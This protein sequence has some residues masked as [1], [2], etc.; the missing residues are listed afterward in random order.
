MPQSPWTI[1]TMMQS[2]CTIQY[3]IINWY[4][5]QIKLCL[6]WKMLSANCVPVHPQPL[7]EHNFVEQINCGCAPSLV[8][9]RL[10]KGEESVPQA[11]CAVCVC[12]VCVRTMWALLLQVGCSFKFLDPYF[13]GAQWVPDSRSK[14][15][16][17]RAV[18]EAGLAVTKAWSV[19]GCVK[20][21]LFLPHRK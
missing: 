16:A 17:I 12:C 8:P 21:V 13:W 14:V 5:H 1:S 18:N 10:R 20:V 3:C 19:C 15:D 4:T 11:L 9:R 2:H 7:T 6:S